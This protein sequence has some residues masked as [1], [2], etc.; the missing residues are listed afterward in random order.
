ML[1]TPLDL[2]PLKLK[3][4]R[5]TTDIMNTF[6]LNLTNK[7]VTLTAYLPDSFEEMKAKEFKKAVLIIPGG[8][9]YFCSDREAEP[10][11]L[12]FLSKD[13]ACFIL[14]YS[15]NEAAKFPQPLEDAEEAL[16]LI[17]EKAE[18]WKI[19]KD[20]IAVVGFSAGGHLAAAL[21]TIGKERPNAQI[22]GY[23]CILEEI[24]KILA[25]PVPS[26]EKEVDSLTPPAFIFASSEDDLVP[27]RHSLEY[28]RALYENKI[29]FE[30]HIFQKGYH[31]FSTADSMVF[32]KK[33]D[34]EY[35]KH[36]AV[37]FDLCITWLEKIF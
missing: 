26:L 18:E 31:G 10:V 24:G 3:P 1:A 11:A 7:N 15:L 28:A 25:H 34:L 14:R 22:L 37:W 21:A 36:C 27:I 5:F 20:K 2:H 23:P 16:T 13:F 19:L 9:Y 8:S 35:N 6:T 32:D 12:K 29:P 4:L 17:R 30:M 33:E